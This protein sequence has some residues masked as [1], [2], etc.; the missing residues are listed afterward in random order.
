[1]LSLLLERVHYDPVTGDMRWKPC[2]KHL[3]KNDHGWAVWHGKFAG[4]PVGKT[5]RGYRIVTITVDGKERYLQA[6][7]VAWA[8]VTGNWPEQEV[9]HEDTDTANNRWCNLRLATSGQNA[10]NKNKDQR[11]RS[12]FKGVHQHTQNGNWIAQIGVGGKKRHLGVF[13]TPEAAAAARASAA[14]IYHGQFARS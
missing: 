6:H 9:D 12:G 14:Q 2:G 5:T 4:K 3:F 10:S 7:R 1:M 13:D 11:N 8:L